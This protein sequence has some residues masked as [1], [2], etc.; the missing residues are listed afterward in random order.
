VDLKYHLRYFWARSYVWVEW[1][2]L[3]VVGSTF[4]LRSFEVLSIDAVP[5]ESP[6]VC[7]IYMGWGGY[8]STS[9]SR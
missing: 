1:K 5:A 8:S 3:L 2:Q 7:V 6:R 4:S 9:D